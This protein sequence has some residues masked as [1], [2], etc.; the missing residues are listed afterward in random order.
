MEIQV[1]IQYLTFN[2]N[3][4]E[5]RNVLVKLEIIIKEA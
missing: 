1:A 4:F 3:I 5:M 2:E